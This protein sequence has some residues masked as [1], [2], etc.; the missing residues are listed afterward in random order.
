MEVRTSHRVVAVGSVAAESINALVDI[1][2]FKDARLDPDNQAR[3]PGRLERQGTGFSRTMHSSRPFTSTTSVSKSVRHR[4]EAI[5]KIDVEDF[6]ND[7]ED[8]GDND[9]QH[10]AEQGEHKHSSDE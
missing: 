4:E 9:Q 7:Y 2:I 3:L 10:Q 5:L 1:L 8:E 6:D